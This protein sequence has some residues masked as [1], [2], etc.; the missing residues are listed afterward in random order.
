MGWVL[1]FSK[2]VIKDFPKNVLNIGKKIV[3]IW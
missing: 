2:V 3:K 1:D